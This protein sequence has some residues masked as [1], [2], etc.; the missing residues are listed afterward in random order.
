MNAAE[1][2]NELEA[3]DDRFLKEM[4]S[5]QELAR[6]YG[7]PENQQLFRSRDLV[8]AWQQRYIAETGNRIYDMHDETHHFSVY[9]ST[10]K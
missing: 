8:L 2:L 10:E 9:F 1:I 6:M 7:D 5:V 4:P 3:M